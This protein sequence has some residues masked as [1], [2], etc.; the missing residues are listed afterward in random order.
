MSCPICLRDVR[1]VKHINRTV[2][3]R[4]RNSPRDK[5]PHEVDAENEPDMFRM[6]ELTPLEAV[7][8]LGSLAHHYPFGLLSWVT[9]IGEKLTLRH[10]RYPT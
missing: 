4:T 1:P 6:D 5:G 3:S 10:A 2:L 7:V 8:I 9:L